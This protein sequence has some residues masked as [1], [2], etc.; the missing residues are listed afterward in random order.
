M[1]IEYLPVEIEAWSFERGSGTTINDSRT[2][3]NVNALADLQ[4]HRVVGL[5]LTWTIYIAS[6]DKIELTCTATQRFIGKDGLENITEDEIK[7]LI[8]FS[9]DQVA[10]VIRKR[11]NEEGAGLLRMK[12]HMIN[13]RAQLKRIVEM[14]KAAM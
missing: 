3:C 6:E 7:E 12:P 10:E 13:E 11:S 5:H 4:T 1:S 8:D 14:V 2:E 9:Y